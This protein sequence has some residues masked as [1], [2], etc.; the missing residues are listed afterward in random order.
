MVNYHN[1][2]LISSEYYADGGVIRPWED[3]Y[4][5]TV[6]TWAQ[7]RTHAGSGAFGGVTLKDSEV[8]SALEYTKNAQKGIGCQPFGDD[9]ASTGP[10]PAMNAAMCYQEMAS[11]TDKRIIFPGNPR[12]A[13]GQNS[14]YTPARL[15]NGEFDWK[16]VGNNEQLKQY[17]VTSAFSVNPANFQHSFE[18]PFPYQ[19]MSQHIM[20]PLKSRAVKKSKSKSRK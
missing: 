9:F 16:L 13:K 3:N 18:S 8:D 19:N 14:F 7:D 10:K 1:M 11:G 15:A 17:P 4:W 6:S 20:P 2:M 5:E 12:N